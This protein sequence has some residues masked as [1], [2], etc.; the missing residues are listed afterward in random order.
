MKKNFLKTLL[1]ICLMT[2]G[3]CGCGNAGENT[4]A[5]TD[6]EE[7]KND[8]DFTENSSKESSIITGDINESNAEK[9]GVCGADIK[10]YYRKN[11]LVI[12]GTGEMDNYTS[13]WGKQPWEASGFRSEIQEIYIEDGVESIGDFA[14]SE[15]T[16]LTRIDIPDSVGYIG[17][18]AFSDCRNLTSVD[19]PDG[20]GYLGDSAFSLCSSLS[21]VNI[22]DS[23]F[24][25]GE[26]TFLQCYR[27]T[28]ITIPDSVDYIADSAFSGCHDLSSIN[29]PDS[30]TS[31]GEHAFELC[32]NLTD[33][34]IPDSVT[35]IGKMAFYSC[36]DL[37]VTYQGQEYTSENDPYG[38]W[39]SK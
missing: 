18:F 1:C 15:C 38:W 3:M 39:H 36:D 4:S 8:N 33:I 9:E 5:R 28:D 35:S 27:L 34:S 13:T 23:I 7:Q 12:R 6:Q 17:D 26:S 10:W 37:K 19:I 29:I 21:S 16:G 24:S 25:I 14:F 32:K 31:I 30:V 11:I 20:V 22:P 2:V